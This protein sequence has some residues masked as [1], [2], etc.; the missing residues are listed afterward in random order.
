MGGNH[1]RRTRRAPH[2]RRY[3]LHTANAIGQFDLRLRAADAADPERPGTGRSCIDATVREPVGILKRITG[4]S[5][6]GL[7]STATT[8]DRGVSR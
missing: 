5:G 7:S 1:A 6:S 4:R 2:H 3:Q 8:Y